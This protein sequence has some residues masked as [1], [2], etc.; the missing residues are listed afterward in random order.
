MASTQQP[1][2]PT[3]AQNQP[4]TQQQAHQHQKQ[5]VQQYE[6]DPILSVKALVPHLKDSL[7]NLMKISACG[8]LHSA[9]IDSASKSSDTTIQRLDKSLEEFYSI[10]DQVELHL[11]LAQECSSQYSDSQRH[12]PHPLPVKPDV[13]AETQTYSQYVSTV[14][15][16]VS[17]A[18]EVH[19]AL[20]D[21]SN[22]LGDNKST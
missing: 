10:C 19:D 8:F 17:C 14:K 21:C 15:S 11:R 1:Q 16:Q 22:K 18:R 20:L 13:N 6:Y 2:Q 3:Q 7:S 4:Q 9:S 12:T 5:A